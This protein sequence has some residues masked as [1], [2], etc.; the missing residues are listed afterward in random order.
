MSRLRTVPSAIY[1]IHIK[2]S[3]HL[4]YLILVMISQYFFQRLLKRIIDYSSRKK[5]VLKYW[6]LD[7]LL[8][9]IGIYVTLPWPRFHELD[10]S[11]RN[12]VVWI[13]CLYDYFQFKSLVIII[14]FMLM[15]GHFKNTIYKPLR[16]YIIYVW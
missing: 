13:W 1:R 16:Y 7:F 11:F 8:V 3:L 10:S 2:E 9:F 6:S 4:R 15:E 14:L 5:T 12:E